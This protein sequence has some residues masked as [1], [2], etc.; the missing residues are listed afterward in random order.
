MQ[1]SNITE[2]SVKRDLACID[3]SFK[4]GQDGVNNMTGDRSSDTTLVTHH[5]QPVVAR[6]HKQQTTST[7]PTKNKNIPRDWKISFHPSVDIINKRVGLK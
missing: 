6:P 1:N 2:S 4:R 3:C 7:R 5:K